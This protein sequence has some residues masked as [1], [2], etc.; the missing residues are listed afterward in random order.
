MVPAEPVEAGNSLAKSDGSKP[1]ILKS[2]LAA[3]NTGIS[4]DPG[5]PNSHVANLNNPSR[6]ATYQLTLNAILN[7]EL[8]DPAIE[9]L[10]KYSDEEDDLDY[11][12]KALKFLYAY[13]VTFSLTLNSNQKE[14]IGNWISRIS[15]ED[16]TKYL[17]R[18][19]YTPEEYD[20]FTEK[21]KL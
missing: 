3:P 1:G 20:I 2:I 17:E 7:H 16:K 14:A 12:E 9:S 18:W 5:H 21:I 4:T 11:E 13:V 15:R 6:T 8:L 19:G 10:I